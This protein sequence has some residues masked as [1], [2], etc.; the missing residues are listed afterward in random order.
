M[1][2]NTSTPINEV[3]FMKEASKREIHNA[4]IKT[5]G[6]YLNL[7]VKNQRELCPKGDA[8]EYY[9][10]ALVAGLY[11]GEKEE[12]AEVIEYETMSGRSMV[13]FDLHPVKKRTAHPSIV[14]MARSDRDEIFRDGRVVYIVTR[15]QVVEFNECKSIVK[16]ILG[17]NINIS[18]IMNS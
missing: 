16:N 17:L 10:S 7:S 6:D 5:I 11:L 1:T 9:R 18:V 14:I 13:Y 3:Y 4:G 2:I 12:Q 15:K 8:T